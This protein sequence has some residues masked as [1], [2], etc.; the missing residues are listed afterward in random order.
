VRRAAVS[1]A[2][3]TDRQQ[4][5]GGQ[6]V[7]ACVLHRAQ[8]DRSQTLTF[9]VKVANFENRSWYSVPATKFAF[10]FVSLVAGL[11]SKRDFYMGRIG[12][13]CVC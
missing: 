7:K 4:R 3:H 6:H 5:H 10:K 12:P 9:F 1:S 13:G 2:E 11:R 8:T